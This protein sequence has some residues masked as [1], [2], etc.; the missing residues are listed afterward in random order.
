MSL[1]DLAFISHFYFII[2]VVPCSPSILANLWDVTDR[3]IDNFSVRVMRS[4]ALLDQK[5]S[6][7]REWPDQR[8]S[9]TTQMQKSRHDGDGGRGSIFGVEASNNSNNDNGKASL[10]ES[11]VRARNGCTLPYLTGAAPV[12]YGHPLAGAR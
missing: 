11:V 8:G 1:I 5:A 12:V 10:A 7:I 4:W 9:L 3:D 6:S 2:F